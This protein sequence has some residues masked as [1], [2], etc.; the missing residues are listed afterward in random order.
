MKLAILADTHF[1][2]RNDSKNFDKYFRKF[3]Q[4]TFFPYIEERGIK[5]LVH[6]G[7]VF[8]R[9]KYVNF[10][11]LRSCKEYFFF[12]LQEL[13][14][15]MKVIPGNHDTYFKNTNE[16]NS[17]D[18]LLR[19]FSNIEIIEQPEIQEIDGK[20]CAFIPW[21][22]AENYDACMQVINQGANYCFGHFEIAGFDMFRGVKNDG[23][24]SRDVLR[25][26]QRVMSGHFHHKSNDDNIHYLGS[27]YQ[28]TW[29]DYQDVRGFH[30]F[31]PSENDLTF[32]ENPNQMFQKIYY[33]DRKKDE[34]FNILEG[35]CVKVI[36]VNKS[37]YQRFDKLIDS[38]YNKGVNELTIH[39]DFSE[40]ESE[41]IEESELDL[42]DT[43]T[44]LT[45]YVDSI[46][47]DKDKGKLKTLLR[48]LYV[49]AQ[50]LEI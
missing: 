36:V 9:R 4:E 26:F 19:E 10:N 39:E 15:D 7:D 2:A 44:L 49:E 11:T 40:F 5:T 30:V 27:P 13:G 48:T 3:F 25:K 23:G 50:N 34:N 35:T 41:A 42:E 16:V 32:I 8:D 22:C 28:F 6:V 24:M 21:I 29:S 45:D 46:E 18:L 37:D 20:T 43:M 14:V 31:E 33:D 12:P 47:S 1:G 17:L 38:L